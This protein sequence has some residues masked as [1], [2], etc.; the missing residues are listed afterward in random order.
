MNNRYGRLK[1]SM[2]LV[3]TMNGD[4]ITLIILCCIAAVVLICGVRDIV[5]DIRDFK[6]LNKD[7]NL[8]K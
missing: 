2:P 1:G 3:T 7:K 5:D 4:T 8:S 6:K